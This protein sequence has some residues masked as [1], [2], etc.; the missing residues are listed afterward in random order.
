MASAETT[1]DHVHGSNLPNHIKRSIT[2]QFRAL[3]SYGEAEL[4][5]PGS[6]K[7]HITHQIGAVRQGIG[8]LG[9]GA[10]LGVAAAELPHGLDAGGK[11]HL[12][13]DG[14]GGAI[15][16]F[17]GA[18]LAAHGVR[19]PVVGAIGNDIR[20]AGGAALAVFGFRKGHDFHTE[21]KLHRGVHPGGAKPLAHGED[22]ILAVAAGL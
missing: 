22:S 14:I 11:G 8:S 18:A 21:R 17:G 6:I 20:N 4:A 16:L 2:D 10:V 9:V 13:I 1:I 12:P 3:M 15:A 7:S 5:P 19:L